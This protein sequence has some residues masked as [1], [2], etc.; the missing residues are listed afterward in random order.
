M[1]RANHR[2]RGIR[3]IFDFSHFRGISQRFVY[4][5]A[6]DIETS[7]LIIASEN[8]FTIA[9]NCFVCSQPQGV[10][11]RTLYIYKIYSII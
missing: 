8:A 3:F 7:L 6:R 11:T 9:D 5:F 1:I 4:L 10:C 2:L